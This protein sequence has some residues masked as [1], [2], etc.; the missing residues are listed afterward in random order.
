MNR[1]VR[2]KQQ[3]E[4]RYNLFNVVLI[5]FLFFNMFVG[6]GEINSI[7]IFW[8][9]F[10]LTFILLFSLGNYNGVSLS[11][12]GIAAILVLLQV[13]SWLLDYSLIETFQGNKQYWYWPVQA[14]ICLGFVTTLIKRDITSTSPYLPLVGFS[15]VLCL[16]GYFLL[17]LSSGRND[18]FLFGPNVYY[19]I[20]AV[21]TVFCIYFVSELPYPAKRKY[22]YSFIFLFFSIFLALQTGSRGAV[23]TYISYFKSTFV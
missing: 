6:N 4:N 14:L 23:P 2:S 1:V 11:A 17:V 19:R 3:M 8:V 7:P 13:Y 15:L 22:L 12:I 9:G 20:I 16:L 18:T 10:P 5:F 21:T